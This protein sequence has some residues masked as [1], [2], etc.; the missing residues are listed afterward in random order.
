MQTLIIITSDQAGGIIV[1]AFL[2]LVSFLN[3]LGRITFSFLPKSRP[4]IPP[5]G[6]PKADFLQVYDELKGKIGR[7]RTMQ[8][9][10]FY[11]TEIDQLYDMY[12]NAIPRPLLTE[13]CG[14]LYALLANRRIHLQYNSL[15]PQVM[16]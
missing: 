3:L 11:E 15:N 12:W 1:M 7:A 14:E 2:L 8:V 13:R 6:G 4:L 16:L 5:V 10:H 9:A